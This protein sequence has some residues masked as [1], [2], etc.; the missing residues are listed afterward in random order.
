MIRWVREYPIIMGV[1][2]ELQRIFTCVYFDY[3]YEKGLFRS[4]R[5]FSYCKFLPLNT[6]LWV[7]VAYFQNPFRF[8]GPFSEKVSVC[9]ARATEFF[10]MPWREIR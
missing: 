7:K 9:F 1:I 5:M 6:I 10:G 4:R 8:F 3:T 2:P